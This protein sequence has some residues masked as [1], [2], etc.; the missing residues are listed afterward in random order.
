MKTAV[1]G[2]RS[3]NDYMFMKE[4]LRFYT[5]TLLISGGAKGADKL[6]ER[7]ADEHNIKKSIYLPDWEKHP[8]TAGILRNN[9]IVSAAELVIA[10]WDGQSKGTK[11]TIERAKLLKKDYVI[12]KCR[13]NNL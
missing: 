5:I 4:V 2:S 3:F 8:K 7:Y 6:A 12:I 13:K 11:Y 10:F 9:L 1:I